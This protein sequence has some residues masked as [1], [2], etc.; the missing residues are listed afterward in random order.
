MMGGMNGYLAA[1]VVL[2]VARWLAGAVAD[3]LN[4]RCASPEMP[5][6]FA[7]WIDAGRYARSQRYLREST[8]LGAIESAAALALTL[9]F[10]LSG[11]FGLLDRAA[12]AAGWGLAGTGL[13]FTG[14]ALLLADLLQL[15]F[16]AYDTFVL[17]ARYGFNRTTPRTFALDRLKAWL[18]TALIGAP[19]FAVLLAFFDRA[20]AGGWV[21]AWAAVA[22]VQLALAYLAPVWI[23]PLFNRFTPLEEGELRGAIERY[24]QAQGF[25]L[26]GIF[27][28][29]G[30]RRSSRGNAYFTGFGRTKRIALYD[31]LVEKHPV[32]EL[33]AV[34]AHE[35]GHHR[36]GHVRRLLLASLLSTG[37]LL[38]LLSL[39]LARPGLY[40]AFGV[41]F[42][43]VGGRPPIYAGMTFF[44][45]LYAPVAFV[46]G[47][48]VH[49]ASRRFEYAADA[50]AA[51][52][53]GDA[54]ALADALRRLSVD[55]LA[56]LTPHPFKVALEYDHP[57]VTA[58]L[59]AL[60][61]L[62]G[63]EA[64]RAAGGPAP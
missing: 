35:I 29:D 3:L 49:A 42:D 10:I 6:A 63:A 8:R 37:L 12:R 33:L 28:I 9:A 30:S 25:R 44:G 62:A 40:A 20:G 53:T 39:F 17:E 57:P 11:G 58:R 46:L 47:L 43:P 48:A 27:S 22:A 5:A 13:A 26:G 60:G 19:L 45:F 4:L 1:V 14:M 52:S 50:F 21:W 38:F 41:S 54:A 55:Q 23:L 15:P 2:L 31:T 16:D 56:N 32:R 51:R 64:D 36:L 61:V 24:A 18:L 34:L 59:Q 7:G